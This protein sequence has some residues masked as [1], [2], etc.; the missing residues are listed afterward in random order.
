MAGKRDVWK[1]APGRGSAARWTTVWT[2]SHAERK[3]VRSEVSSG[4]KLS[5]DASGSAA[6]SATTKPLT[7]MPQASAPGRAF[8]VA[9]AVGTSTGFMSASRSCDTAARVSSRWWGGVA[10]VGREGS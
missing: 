6:P 9:S 4:T 10:G 2:P 7:P 8:L 5:W 1:S 3:E